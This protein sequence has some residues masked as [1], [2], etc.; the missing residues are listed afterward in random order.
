VFLFQDDYSPALAPNTNSDDL[1]AGYFNLK[2]TNQEIASALTY[3]HGIAKSK[4]QVARILKRLGLCRRYNEFFQESPLEDILQ[5]MLEEVS[6]SGKCLGYRAMWRRLTH[7]R[8]LHVRRDTV[9]ELIRYVDPDGVEQRR[10]R[11]L[12]RRQYSNPGPNYL[13]HMDGYDKL[14]PYGFA[15][16]GAIDGYS[17]RILWL[18]VANSNN[19]PDLISSYYLDTMQK[20]NVVPRVLRADM[21]TENVGVESLQCYFRYDNDDDFAGIKSFMYGKSTSNQRIEAWWCMF[22]RLGGDWWI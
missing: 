2:Y 22:R 5:A 19:N 7:R 6:G 1:V 20:L 13:W 17:R 3:T 21:G 11:R 12:M 16:H 8:A 9:M 18:E 4:Y 14:K 15:I 10:R